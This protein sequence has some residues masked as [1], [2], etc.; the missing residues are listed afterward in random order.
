M[1]NFVGISIQLARKGSA[2]IATHNKSSATSLL[3]VQVQSAVRWGSTARKLGDKRTKYK[4]LESVPD[5]SDPNVSIDEFAMAMDT[6]IPPEKQAHVDAMKKLISGGPKSVRS[7]YRDVPT[8]EEIDKLNIPGNFIPKI[9]PNARAIIDFALMHIPEKGGPR[10]S[11]HKKRMALKWARK[12]VQDAL[13]KKQKI[14]A[15]EKKHVKMRKQHVLIKKYKKLAIQ[16]YG[17]KKTTAAAAVPLT[18]M[19]EAKN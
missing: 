5:T 7:L 2:F 15:H 9:A 6:T 11:K 4:T 12:E 8:P 14:A 3:G 10:R 16:L 1:N 18:V 17:P 19:T 13:V